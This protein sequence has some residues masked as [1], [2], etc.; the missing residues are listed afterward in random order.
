[1]W[2]CLF[3]RS[4]RQSSSCR[5]VV[6]GPTLRPLS[7]QLSWLIYVSNCCFNKAHSKTRVFVCIE[8][9]DDAAAVRTLS[10][11]SIL[12]KYAN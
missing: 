9:E 5:L 7:L 8:E 12:K 3:R 11:S 1:M 10:Q 6:Q 2:L 4:N